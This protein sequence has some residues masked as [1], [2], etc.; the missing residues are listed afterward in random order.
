MLACN[1][2]L[3]SSIDLCCLAKMATF[4]IFLCII[5]YFYRFKIYKICTLFLFKK[6]TYGNICI[7]ERYSELE[8][9]HSIKLT[10]KDLVNVV[11]KEDEPRV[12]LYV[13]DPK[14]YEAFFFLGEEGIGHSFVQNFIETDDLVD[15][16]EMIFK[17]NMEWYFHRKFVSL[18]KLKYKF[19]VPTYSINEDLKKEIQFDLVAGIWGEDMK[20]AKETMNGLVAEKLKKYDTTL[21][22]VIFFTEECELEGLTQIIIH[23][24]LFDFSNTFIRRMSSG[25]I[26]EEKDIVDMHV[27][28]EHIERFSN[29]NYEKAFSYWINEV[30]KK[31]CIDRTFYYHLSFLKFLF[32]NGYL[33]MNHYFCKK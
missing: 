32:K 22:D 16:F 17:N 28:I 29:E 11:N 3:S 7:V 9:D 12:V 4:G 19:D 27:S 2:F 8:E 23:N 25:N 10:D 24:G 1:M 6:L 20:T 5:Y 14:F 21:S 15:L 31:E 30:K 13:K 33:S 26:L 18:T